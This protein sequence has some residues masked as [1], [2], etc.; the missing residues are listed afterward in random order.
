VVPASPESPQE[1]RLVRVF[2]CLHFLP[3]TAHSQ[4]WLTPHLASLA[5]ICAAA[6]LHH[7]LNEKYAHYLLTLLYV[8]LTLPRRPKSQIQFR[9]RPR[10]W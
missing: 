9:E 1:A 10:V 2:C 6:T 5:E 8:Y 7:F 4:P 3:V